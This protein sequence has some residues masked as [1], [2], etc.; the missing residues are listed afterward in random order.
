MTPTHFDHVLI[1]TGQATGTLIAGLPKSETIAVVE[2]ARVGGTCVN[3]GCTPTKTLVASAKVAHMVRRAADYGVRVD[4]ASVDFGAVMAR[5][6]AMRRGS[7]D[8]LESWLQKLDHVTL[9]KG[10]A[11]FDGPKTVRVGETRITG[12]HIYLNVGAR[13]RIPDIPGLSDVPWLDNARILE[14]DAL[15]EHLVILGG[16]YIGLEFGQMFRRFGASVTILEAGDRL[17]F[18]EDEDVS[19]AVKDVLEGEGI[20]VRPNAR[21]LRVD[22]NGADEAQGVAVTLE[23][24][25]VVRGSHLL[26]AVGRVPN[27]DRLNLDA[28]GI[29]TDERGFIEVDDR[30]MTGVDGVFALGDVN[31]RGAFTHTA[32]NDAEIALD[33]L[34]G[35]PRRLSDRIPVFAMFT[36]PP[37]ARVGMT[38]REAIERGH[39]VLEAT[40][41]MSRISRAKEMGETDGFVRLL[42]D[43]ESD[44]IL[45]ATIFG[46]HGDE[47]VNMFAAFMYSG[48]PCRDY[49]RAVLAHPT[50]SELMPWILDDLALVT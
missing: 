15:P 21:V 35:G 45:G 46:L 19:E 27:S 32:V 29:A 38:K 20:T 41:A 1:G 43:A 3:T 7:S 25:E 16:S 10:W 36:D 39:R 26:V 31:G 49:R 33:A 14:L 50:V 37:L 12:E 8:G 44:L 24:G 48:R 2:G 30:T 28:A 40:R 9:L 18:R 5:M 42:V 4:G 23:G 17:V 13:A 11:S 47:V 34:R 22:R 6:N